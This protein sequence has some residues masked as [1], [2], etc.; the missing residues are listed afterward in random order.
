[1]IDLMMGMFKA[2]L[3]IP[4]GWV[5]WVGILMLFNIVIP[6]FYL[7]TIEGQVIAFAFVMGAMTQMLIF[8][9]LGYVRLMGIGHIFWL[10]LVIWLGLNW[11]KYSGTGFSEIFIGGVILVD[12]ISLI[13]DAYLVMRYFAGDRE[14]TVG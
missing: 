13:I 12:S 9:R 11:E 4:T 7:G 2:M 5:I 1:M 10:P 8:G 14:P 3:K 6:I